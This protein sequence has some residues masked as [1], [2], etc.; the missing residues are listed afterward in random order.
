M[1]R[2]FHNVALTLLKLT[3]IVGFIFA[4]DGVNLAGARTA[5]PLSPF[6]TT[7][8]AT[9]CKS[10]V[11][12][13]DSTSEGMTSA[14]YLPKVSQRL[15][16]QLKRIGVKRLYNRISGA[17]SIV[18]TFDGIPNGYMVA[19]KLHA[20]GF[21][22]CW[23]IAL[24]TNDAADIAAGSHV[25]RDARIQRMMSVIGTQ[26]VLWVSVRTLAD[27]PAYYEESNM[28]L[29]NQALLRACP[30]HPHMLV[31]DWAS[32]VKPSWFIGDGVHY[33]STGYMHRSHDTAVALAR[34]FPAKGKSVRH[35]CLV[36]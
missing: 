25:G 36:V 18:E 31:F 6:T 33:T 10:V 9:S 28:K 22:G 34:A 2:K 19:K 32:V 11:Y 4:L 16:P 26:R 12:I 14:D 7:P 21:N 24:G 17:R 23:I 8:R 27:A 15:G 1:M 3:A 29:W 35:G 20:A 13:G 30:A 5:A